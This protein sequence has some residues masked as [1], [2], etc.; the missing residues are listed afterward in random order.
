MCRQGKSLDSSVTIT[1]TEICK[2]ED[3]AFYQRLEEKLKWR[4]VW[5]RTSKEMEL[6][7]ALDSKF[8]LSKEPYQTATAV[9]AKRSE[10]KKSRP[11]HQ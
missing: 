9:L 8:H 4:Y 3:L 2:I 6:L 5:D 7:L 11:S 10:G 1:A